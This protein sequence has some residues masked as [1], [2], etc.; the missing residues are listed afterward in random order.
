MNKKLLLI[1]SIIIILTAIII[2]SF[3]SKKEEKKQTFTIT[4]DSLLFKQEYEAYN[5]QETKDKKQYLNLSIPS[6]NPIVYT[7]YDDLFDILNNSGIIYLGDP[8]C[9]WCRSLISVLIN[10]AIDYGIKEIY[11][12]NI[13][14]DRNILTLNK[15]N[16][17]ITEKKGSDNYLKLVDKLY[18]YLDVYKGLNDES[19]KRIYL[20]LVI[21]VNNG[22]IIG[23]EQSLIT[24]C[25]RVEKD[26]YIPMNKEE[27]NELKEI[28]NSYYQKIEK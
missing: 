18:N 7:S 24:Y 12:L 25:Q 9:P 5:N 1:I 4:N 27:K 20:P 23:L 28:F 6:Y 11:Y 13:E 26:P 17:I 19:I 15:K 3:T 10:S 8:E 16:K 14:N 21:F 22:K 2:L